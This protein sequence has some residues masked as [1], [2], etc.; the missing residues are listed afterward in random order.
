MRMNMNGTST[1]SCTLIGGYEGRKY[2]EGRERGDDVRKPT[3]MQY[4]T[5]ES[6]G[7]R[8]DA[9]GNDAIRDI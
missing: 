4:P 5:S 3:R 6:P 8:D 2:L 1:S 7:L 9:A